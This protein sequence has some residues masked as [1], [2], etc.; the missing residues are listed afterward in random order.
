MRN[1]K[2]LAA[3]VVG[4]IISL[5]VCLGI[6]ESI[7]LD[8]PIFLESYC[9]YRI[10]FNEG[11]QDRQFH[12]NLEFSI[13]YITNV[14][15]DK[16]VIDIILPEAPELYVYASNNPSHFFTGFFEQGKPQIGTT[17]GRYSK[18]TVFVTIDGYDGEP[19]KELV[20][21]RATIRYSNGDTQEIELG[22]II[23]HGDVYKENHLE[24]RSNSSSSD[25]SSQTSFK[26]EKDII[27][28]EIDSPLLNEVEGMLDIKIN[29]VDYRKISGTVFEVGSYINV[30]TQL[31]TPKTFDKGFNTYNIM[32][33]L[34]FKDN[35][36]NLYTQRIYNM[37]YTPLYSGVFR[38]TN[39]TKYLH[40][41]GEI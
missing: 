37:N 2:V 24:S 16:T 4:I 17:Y 21:T 28:I 1:H 25:G 12:Q 20:L 36:G 38:F 5:A 39:I 9:E 29:D 14:T 11:E 41:K 27:L 40:E 7:K 33:I 22:K 31:T 19:F 10:N 8:K 32:P 26:V 35:D 6:S 3:G 23:I 13:E 34:Y 30:N 15:D 18:R